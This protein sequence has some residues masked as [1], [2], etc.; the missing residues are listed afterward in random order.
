MRR[1]NASSL[2]R[3]IFF[4]Y[5]IAMSM[6]R[7]QSPL[8]RFFTSRLFLIVILV[9]AV[10]LAINY[11]RAYYQEYKVKQEIAALREEVKHLEQKKIESL[12]ILQYVTSDAFVEE[13]ARTE[14]NLKKPGEKVVVINGNDEQKRQGGEGSEEQKKRY[15]SNPL[16]WWYYIT[17]H[18]LPE[19]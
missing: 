15:L 6:Q 8:R 2:H 12:K 13:K 5:T 14:L 17:R 19:D 16:K 10:F 1:G 7:S 18:S 3:S 4:C 11:A 9:V